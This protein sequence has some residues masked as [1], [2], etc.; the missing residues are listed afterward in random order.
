MEKTGYSGDDLVE[1]SRSG[2]FIWKIFCVEGPTTREEYIVKI[3][4]KMFVDREAKSLIWKDCEDEIVTGR[5]D[6]VRSILSEEWYDI[7]S[8]G[9][10]YSATKLSGLDAHFIDG[11]LGYRRS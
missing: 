7:A 6:T 2:R 1:E 5:A 11:T 10:G 9:E 4:R 3:L 8:L